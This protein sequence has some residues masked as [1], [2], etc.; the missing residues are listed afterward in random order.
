MT[1][2]LEL[3]TRIQQLRQEHNKARHFCYGYR[4]LD[5]GAVA[6]YS[7]DAGEPAGSSGPPILAVL[8][9]S[10][11]V[12]CGCIVVRHFGGTKLGIPGLIEAYGAATSDAFENA[13]IITHERTAEIRV[14]APMKFQPYLLNALKRA[15]FKA[16]DYKYTSRF[17]MIM[18]V[19]FENSER[20]VM[21]VLL[22]LS[23]RA[24]ESLDDL[25]GYLDIKTEILGESF[26]ERQ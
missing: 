20:H 12:N 17:E 3:E 7:S 9:Q 14:N 21:Q 1:D 16:N 2:L 15:G 22:H 11:L 26:T 6:E 10:D 18:C 19:P 5:R 25:L 13:Q 23:D 4:I 24:Y 8:K